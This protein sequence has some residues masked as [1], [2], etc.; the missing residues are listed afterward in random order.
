MISFYDC[1][2]MNSADDDVVG[3]VDVE[4]GDA[5]VLDD[6]LDAVRLVHD[7]PAQRVPVRTLQPEKKWFEIKLG[8][9]IG[10]KSK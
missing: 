4:G 3:D 5:G 9:E 10:F 6:V 2:K 7:D 8:K 1:V